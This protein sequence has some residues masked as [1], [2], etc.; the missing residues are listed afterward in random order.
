[1]KYSERLKPCPFCG[2]NADLYSITIG[3]NEERVFYIQ[4]DKCLS[5]SGKWGKK[6]NAIDMWNRRTDNGKTD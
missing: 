5:R 1:M 6:E 3:F 4:C 2:G